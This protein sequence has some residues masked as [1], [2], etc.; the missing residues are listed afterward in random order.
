MNKEYLNLLE[1]IR[2]TLED[3]EGYQEDMGLDNPAA[4]LHQLE[5]ILETLVEIQGMREEME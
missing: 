1:R 5:K 4:Y 2:D 3:I